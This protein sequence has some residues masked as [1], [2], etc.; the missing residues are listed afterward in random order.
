MLSAVAGAGTL[1]TPAQTGSSVPLSATAG[2]GRERA[3]ARPG[4]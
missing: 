4:G 3:A 2:L 1:A